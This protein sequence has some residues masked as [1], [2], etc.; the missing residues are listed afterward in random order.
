MD[1]A[2]STL[3]T[4]NGRLPPSEKNVPIILHRLRSPLVEKRLVV[5]CA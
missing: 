2:L 3:V 1:L 5:P 4:Y